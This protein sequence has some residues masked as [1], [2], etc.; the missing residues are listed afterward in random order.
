MINWNALYHDFL[1]EANCRNVEVVNDQ[2]SE[3]C[4]GVT[5]EKVILDQDIKIYILARFDNVTDLN[6]KPLS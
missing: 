5:G 1:D 2:L 6:N 4:F 3:H